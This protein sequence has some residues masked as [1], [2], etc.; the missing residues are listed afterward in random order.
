M[1]TSLTADY[2]VDYKEACFR[3]WYEAGRPSIHLQD[4]IPFAPDGRKPSAM[5]LG[6]WMRGGDGRISWDEHADELDAELFRRLDE[7][8]IQ[9]RARLVQELAE[10]GRQLKEKAKEFLMK[11]DPFK[12]NPAAAVR[13]FIAGIEM[14]FKYSGMAESLVM[15]SAMTPKQLE[16][17]ALFL[18]GK[19]ENADTIDAVEDDVPRE[20]DGD[21]NPED[22]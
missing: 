14:Q 10:D 9:K 1:S 15:I 4:V 21:S 12:D 11:E 18:L 3:A 16:K 2:S 6:K 7:K 13:A 19:N 8:S 20:E 22:D 5:T 17:E